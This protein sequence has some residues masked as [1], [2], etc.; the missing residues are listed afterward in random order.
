MSSLKKT[1]R[2]V[3]L[4]KMNLN[5]YVHESVTQSE[6]I[7]FHS[8]AQFDAQTRAQISNEKLMTRHIEDVFSN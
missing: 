7:P 4:I 8:D 3:R 5:H 1:Y 6:A 2:Y